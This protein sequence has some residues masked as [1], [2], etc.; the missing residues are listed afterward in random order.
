MTSLFLKAKHWQ[1]FL[2]IFAIPF[3]LQIV[4]MSWLMQSAMEAETITQ[5]S[6]FDTFSL[7][8]IVMILYIGGLFGWFWSVGIGLQK[9]MP[10][11]FRLRTGV[12]KF[13]VLFPLIYIFFIVLSLMSLDDTFGQPPVFLSFFPIGILLHLFAMFC[14]FYVMWFL[15]KAIKTAEI[16]APV[17]FSDFVGEF[18]LIW[19]FLI[20]VWILQPKINQIFENQD[21]ADDYGGKDVLD[22]DRYLKD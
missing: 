15:A 10:E 1:L 7:M 5:E 3:T 19:F 13:F 22:S 2:A 14:M 12:F 9:R 21:L 11:E 8:A 6:F 18:F 20:G 17:K 16:Q 4:I